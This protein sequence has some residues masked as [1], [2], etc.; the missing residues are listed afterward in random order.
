MKKQKK[1]KYL[2]FP[3]INTFDHEGP[4]VVSVMQDLTIGV[5]ELL[6]INFSMDVDQR[7]AYTEHILRGAELNKYKSILLE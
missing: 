1:Q 7:V 2:S 3:Y 4:V 6:E 5:F